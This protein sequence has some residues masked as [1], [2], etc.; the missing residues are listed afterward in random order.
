MIDSHHMN[1]YY[2][3]REEVFIVEKMKYENSNLLHHVVV[4]KVLLDR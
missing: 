4:V 2:F 1:I 3:E